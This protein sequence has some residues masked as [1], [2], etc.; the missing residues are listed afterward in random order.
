MLSFQSHA[1][2]ILFKGTHTNILCSIFFPSMIVSSFDIHR[3]IPRKF[4]KKSSEIIS[5]LTGIRSVSNQ[6]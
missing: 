6:F 4:T 2:L 3:N 1:Q 5:G